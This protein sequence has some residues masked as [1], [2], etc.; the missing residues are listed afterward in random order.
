[1][2]VYRPPAGAY[3]EFLSEFSD[4]LAD[5]VLSSDKVVIVGDF[6]IHMDVDSDSLKL[7]F[8]SLLE[9]LGISQKVNEATALIIPWIWSSPM[10]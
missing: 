5:L 10:V 7:A 2:V 3:L 9:L 6:N 8:T 1:M 4:F